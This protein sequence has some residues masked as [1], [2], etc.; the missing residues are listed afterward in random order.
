MGEQ[1]RAVNCFLVEGAGQRGCPDG[2]RCFRRR[3]DRKGWDFLKTV[4]KSCHRTCFYPLGVPETR[5]WQKSVSKRERGAAKKGVS[6][7]EPDCP[8]LPE[9]VA[10]CSQNVPILIRFR[11]KRNKVVPSI[12]CKFIPYLCWLSMTYVLKCNKMG[13]FSLHFLS[14][15]L[16]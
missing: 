1:N 7:R 10:G 14:L 2:K 11:A 4:T 8:T 13:T 12:C 5:G 3:A 15:F 6:I 16:P 9:M